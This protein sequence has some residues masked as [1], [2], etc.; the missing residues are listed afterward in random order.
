M[1]IEMFDPGFIVVILSSM[2]LGFVVVVVMY[3]ILYY[4]AS[5][6]P[7]QSMSRSLHVHC[8]IN[9]RI[10][11]YTCAV[12]SSRSYLGVNCF[13]YIVYPHRDTLAVS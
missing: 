2:V 7:S 9:R 5:L 1:P 12:L 13:K 8:Y 11:L 4:V 3:H 10:L 6:A